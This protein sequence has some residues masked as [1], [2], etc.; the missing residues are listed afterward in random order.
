ML[1][2]ANMNRLLKVTV[3][4]VRSVHLAICQHGA[5]TPMGQSFTKIIFQIVTRNCQHIMIFVKSDKSNRHVT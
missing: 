1:L 5:E 3:S 2:D 4:L